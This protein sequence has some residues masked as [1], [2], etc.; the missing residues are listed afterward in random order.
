[1]FKNTEITNITDN[2]SNVFFCLFSFFDCS[3]T[4]MSCPPPAKL[5][6]YDITR[7]QKIPIKKGQNKFC[8]HGNNL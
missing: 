4:A 2:T 5:W 8:P 3:D 1:M 6:L 7:C